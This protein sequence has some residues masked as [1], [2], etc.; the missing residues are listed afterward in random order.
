MC[1]SHYLAEIGAVNPMQFR[2]AV[3]IWLGLLTAI[4]ALSAAEPEVKV[5]TPQAY[6]KILK[7][8]LITPSDVSL[9]KKIFRSQAKGDF[10]K[11]ADLTEDLENHILL[12]HVLA[13]K[14]LHP[15]YTADYKELQAWLE[16]YSDLPQALRIY[17]L[18]QRKGPAEGLTPPRQGIGSQF[19]R[20]WNNADLA[21]RTPAEKQ[22]LLNQ[23]TKFRRELNRGR[24]R[25]ARLVLEQPRFR[26]LAPDKYWD[27][28]AASLAMKYFVDN[29]NKLALQ[30]AVR[31]SRR[32]TSGMA[33][34]V[35][36]LASWR[37]KNYRNA[38][39]YF[40][41]LADSK[42]PDNWLVSA[43]AFWAYRSYSRLNDQAAAKKM[44]LRAARFPHTFYGILGAFKAGRPL[45]YN[46]NSS[47]Y[48][49]NFDNLDYV[50]DL[51][52]SPAIRRAI[53]LIHA[54]RPDLAEDEIRYAFDN[55]TP[56]QQEAVIFIAAQYKMHALAIY[57]C[58]Q[59]SGNKSAYDRLAY[60][61]PEWV[62][63]G[64]WRVE[65]ALVL[66]LIRQESSFKVDARSAA[67]AHGLMQLMPN[68]AYHIT[69]DRSI[70]TDSSRLLA[71]DYNLELG[72][73][74]VEY[75]LSKPF[76]NGNLFYLMAAYNAGPGN[77]VK[78]QKNTVYGNDPLMFIEAVPSAETRIY[79]ERVTANYWIY[80]SRFGM[81]SP[82]LEQVAAGKW[83]M[84]SKF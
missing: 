7:Y 78:W 83:P 81:P 76:I 82:T 59:V 16:Q 18:A 40:Q 2:A 42:N 84:L 48:L 33:P 41:Q 8:L 11:A 19:I 57:C 51:L 70:K 53:I 71:A 73:R 17:K 79:I 75:L 64:P 47:A 67:G 38:A 68:T 44:L 15:D 21:R 60:P 14:Y 22:Y 46:W 62:R 52:A 32:K 72:Q 36:G 26:R 77:L 25:Q 24:T 50:Y 65:K 20:G 54:K 1:R 4:P 23:V 58:K 43:G 31:A 63:Q 80:N 74:Y 3:F 5:I 9:Y 49:S 66:G 12:G 29:Y 55:M 6:D 61:I 28:L 56:K 30:W 39:R 10:E 13:E 35:A 37:M 34:W 45:D 27:E 69:R